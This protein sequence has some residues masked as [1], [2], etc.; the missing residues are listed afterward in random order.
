VRIS[1]RRA[2]SIGLPALVLGL[3]AIA[4]MGYLDTY[5]HDYLGQSIKNTGI[6]YGVVRGINALVSVLQSSEVSVMLVSVNIGEL[7]DP[8]N[9]LI[10]RFS[11]VLVIALGALVFQQVMLGIVSHN[12]F[13][14]VMTALALLVLYSSLVKR[15][16]FHGYLLRALLLSLFL[17]FALAVT[18]LCASLV[19]GWFLQ[20]PMQEQTEA[21][22]ELEDQL[23]NSRDALAGEASVQPLDTEPGQRLVAAQQKQQQLDHAL[24]SL[25]Q[26]IAAAETA[27]EVI[28]A[29][30]P[31]YI[32]WYSPGWPQH[33]AAQHQTLRQLRLERRQLLEQRA[34][35]ESELAQAYEAQECLQLKAQGKSCSVWEWFDSIKPYEH[36]KRSLSSLSDSMDD[37]VENI[38]D[39]IVGLLLQS[40][41]LP[42]LFFY[43]IYRG[44]G[45]LWQ[46]PVN[47]E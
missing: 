16:P 2:A 37:Y 8:L 14:L 41:I 46:L 12:V 38:M 44:A 4:W 19:D 11:D 5:S 47:R 45:L 39:L 15:L 34:E 18:V 21:M 13:N 3:L 7:L 33:L 9:D 32:S 36:Y 28:E 30:L 27:I 6:L 24:A 31:W 25:E 35:I 17:R 10:E 23:V 40:V 22:I 42:L 1:Y 20:Q 43:S 29:D 26:G